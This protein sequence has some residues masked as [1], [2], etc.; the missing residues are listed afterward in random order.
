MPIFKYV[1][2]DGYFTYCLVEALSHKRQTKKDY[3]RVDISKSGD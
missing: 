2:E 3:K 1:F